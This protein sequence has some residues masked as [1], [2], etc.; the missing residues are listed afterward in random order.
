MKKTAIKL[1]IFIVMSM[2]VT[3]CSNDNDEVI[4][5]PF[6]GEWSGTFSGG[7]SGTWSITI[8]NSGSVSGEV[9]SANLQGFLDINGKVDTS[10]DFRATAGSAANGATYTGTFTENSGSGEWENS[11]DQI[12]GTWEGNRN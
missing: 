3:A 4:N 5:V 7:D 6:A 1:S 9:F 12:S 11:A 10:G 2:L 8:S